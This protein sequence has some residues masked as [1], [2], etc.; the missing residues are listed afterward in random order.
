M[1]IK[2]YEMK[3]KCFLFQTRVTEAGERWPRCDR[4]EGMDDLWRKNGCLIL[5][6]AEE[7][8]KCSCLTVGCKSIGSRRKEERKGRTVS[9][10]HTFLHMTAIRSVIWG[11]GIHLEQRFHPQGGDW[12]EPPLNDQLGLLLSRAAKDWVVL[13]SLTPA[14]SDLL[15][16]CCCFCPFLSHSLPPY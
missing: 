11:S 2:L 9:S 5:S 16:P 10:I 7:E 1:P 12:K 8:S 14:P 6:S 13:V 15:P 3:R 4:K